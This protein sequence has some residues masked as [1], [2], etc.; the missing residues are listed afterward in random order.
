MRE[1]MGQS[2]CI[3]TSCSRLAVS[4]TARL[5][6]VSE[7][8]AICKD[9]FSVPSFLTQISGEIL[10]RHTPPRLPQSQPKM[11]EFANLPAK[12]RGKEEEIDQVSASS[13]SELGTPNGTLKRKSESDGQCSKKKKKK[14]KSERGAKLNGMSHSKRRHS[15]SKPA[16]DPRDE[17]SPLRPSQEP[18]GTRSPSP[19]ID[20]DGLSRPSKYQYHPSEQI[21]TAGRSGDA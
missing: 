18:A 8:C 11:V 5:T 6:P 14:S 3:K 13:S 17:A 16:R 9:P 20:F 15:V 1:S 7:R 2:E 12:V 21:L 19:V 4:N 10:I